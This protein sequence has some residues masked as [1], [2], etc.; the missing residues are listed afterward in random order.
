MQFLQAILERGARHKH[1]ILS[2]AAELLHRLRALRGWV[3][4]RMGFID[5]EEVDLIDAFQQAGE[6]R[7]GGDR[8]PALATPLG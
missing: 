8:H 3:L 7:I 5:G 2:Q 1:G 6:G 4:D